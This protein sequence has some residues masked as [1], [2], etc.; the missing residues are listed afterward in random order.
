MKE[1]NL[2]KYKNK[3]FYRKIFKLKTAILETKDKKITKKVRK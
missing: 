2:K 1:R 3:I